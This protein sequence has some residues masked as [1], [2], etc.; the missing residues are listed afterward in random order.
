MLRI[1][2]FDHL[3]L[4]FT[5][6]LAAVGTAAMPRQPFRQVVWRQGLRQGLPLPGMTVWYRGWYPGLLFGLLGLWIFSMGLRPPALLAQSCTAQNILFVASSST[7]LEPRDE[8]LV[9]YLRA[10]GHQVTIRSGAALQTAD[11]DGKDLL[12]VSESVESVE[13]ERKLRTVAVPLVTWEGWLQDDLGMTGTAEYGDYGEN[14]FQQDVYVV[15]PKHPLADGLSGVVTT[16]T[17]KRNKFHWGIPNAN[18]IIVAVDVRND[19]QA[20]LYAYEQGAQMVGLTAP[21]RRVFL[22]NAAGLDLTIAG[23]RLFDAAVDWA[24]GCTGSEP[25]ATPTSTPPPTATGTPTATAVIPTPSSTASTT[26]TPPVTTTATVSRTPSPTSTATAT[27]TAT[28]TATPTATPT[29]IATAAP[30]SLAFQKQ[31]LLFIDADE[32]GF[33]SNG[34]TLLYVLT[35]RNE[36]TTAVTSIALQDVPDPNTKLI[37]GS[38]RTDRGVVELGNQTGDTQV[39]VAL[40]D[41]AGQ[42]ATRLL[43]QVQVQAMEQITTLHNQAQVRYA[44]SNPAGQGEQMSDDPDTTEGNDATV[45]QTN[46]SISTLQQIYLPMIAR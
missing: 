34:D 44:H 29:P 21:A 16:T 22:H 37:A 7:T 15:N 20:T 1:H 45:T 31:D 39:V 28:A 14:L 43:F 23:W 25:T 27:E 3:R 6:W 42:E 35:L 38:V 30:I 10:L 33:V 41:L 26:A 19:Q 5:R 46:Q 12:I 4:W 36:G 11:A 32:D 24:L 13:V 2:P 17:T 8:P 40:G 9:V 18:A